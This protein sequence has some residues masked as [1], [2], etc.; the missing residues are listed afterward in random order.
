MSEITGPVVRRKIEV[1]YRLMGSKCLECG[2]TYFPIREFCEVDGRKSRMERISFFDSKGVVVSGSVVR[3]PLK[4]FSRLA[5][6]ISVIASFDGVNIPGRLTDQNPSLF[7][8]EVDVSSFIGK[9]VFPVFR[10]LYEN[11][12]GII[13]Y[14]SLNF[15]EEGYHRFIPYEERELGEKSERPGIVGYGVYIPRYRIRV[16]EI[17]KQFHKDPSIYEKGMGLIEK[18]V[19]NLDEDS[20]T[21][22]VEAGRK[23]LAHA[24][25]PRNR[26]AEVLVGTESNPYAVKPIASSVIEALAV[27]EEYGGGYVCGGVDLEFACKAAT[28]VFK[29]AAS[30]PLTALSGVEFSLVI[31]TDNSQA[32]PGDDLDYAAG[33]GAA[34]FVFG[35]HGVIASVEACVS[36]TSDTPDFYRRDGQAFPRHEDRFTGEPA[37]FKHVVN[38]AKVLMEKKGLK[39]KDI[40]Y[41]VFHQPNGKFP[42]RA[43][44]QL[45]FEEE[46][47][48]PGLRVPWIGNTYSASSLMGLAATL[49][50]AEPGQR[51]L[52]V[53]YGSG[54]GSDAVLFKIEKPIEERRDRVVPVEEYINS[55]HKIYIDYSFYRKSKEYTLGS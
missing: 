51:I 29:S 43:A 48:A 16:A 13:A 41:V 30:M 22:A 54:A 40:D 14:S 34:A 12:A 42:V 47:Y 38:C 6:Y 31:G 5:P 52:L 1:A 50:I 26:I 36:Y 49:D 37:Y 27:G 44:H 46:Q 9:E 25:V 23:A 15:V 3:E 39:S 7:E 18:S 21:M 8:G 32:F 45:G 19:C 11:V 20:V 28:A 53:S 33:A 10:R 17:A 4:R 55:P 24:G 35:R 2:R